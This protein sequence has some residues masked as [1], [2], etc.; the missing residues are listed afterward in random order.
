MSAQY[1][2]PQ[3][4]TATEI[5]QLTS[6]LES[7][8]SLPQ[9]E[10]AWATELGLGARPSDHQL[11]VPFLVALFV[12]TVFEALVYVLLPLWSLSRTVSACCLSKPGCSPADVVNALGQ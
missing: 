12:V 10:E 6:G 7:H 8:P 5:L 1:Y 3:N 4:H 2:K 9:P 11:L